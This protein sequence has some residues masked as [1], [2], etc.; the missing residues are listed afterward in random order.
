VIIEQD[1]EGYGTEVK[2]QGYTLD[3]LGVKVRG[4]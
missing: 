4:S 1:E 3:K 2:G